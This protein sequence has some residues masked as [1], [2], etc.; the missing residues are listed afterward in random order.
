[1]RT[2]TYKVDAA[3]G[4]RRRENVPGHILSYFTGNVQVTNIDAVDSRSNDLVFHPFS[5]DETD[6]EQ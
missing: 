2:A 4:R 3:S 1:M 6:G 5:T